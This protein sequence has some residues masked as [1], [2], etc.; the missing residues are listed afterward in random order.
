MSTEVETPGPHYDIATHLK[1]RNADDSEI[2]KKSEI[3][4]SKFSIN[5][6]IAKE[7]TLGRAYLFFCRG[8]RVNSF[9]K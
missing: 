6:V 8:A 4:T 2:F 1:R 5:S 9:L 3:L 7:F